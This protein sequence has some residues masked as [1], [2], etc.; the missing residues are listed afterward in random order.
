MAKKDYYGILGVD[1]QADQDE[2]KKAY[3]KLA[4]KYHPDK[5]NGKSEQEAKE[6]EEHFKEVNEAYQVLSDTEKRKK[7]DT[8]GTVDG[9]FDGWMS[10][11]DAMA[12]FMKHFH[13][14][15]DDFFGDSM[16]G[17]HENTIVKGSSI[18]LNVNIGISELYTN[19]KKTVKYDKY[20]KCDDCNG[21][22]SLNGDTV[23][24]EHCKGT[25]KIVETHRKGFM[26]MQNITM[27]PHCNGKGVFPKHVC[28]KCAG[29]GLLIAENEYTFEIPFGIA[30]GNGIKIPNLGHSTAEPNGVDGDLIIIFNILPEKGFSVSNDNPLD[31]VYTLNLPVLDCITGCECEIQHLDGKKY[32]INVRQGVKDGYKM[33]IPRLGFRNNRINSQVGDLIVKINQVMPQNLGKEDIKAVNKLK[34]LNKFR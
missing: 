32:R 28:P 16:F 8:F 33:R 2:I 6:A 11:A 31:M 7:Y 19:A 17:G 26:M 22:G 25:G 20:I 5:Q 4:L 23:M 21:T 10:G 29:H 14:F 34:K 15:G 3:R 12:E 18:R 24:C 9:N 27:C 13:G 1:R 30:N